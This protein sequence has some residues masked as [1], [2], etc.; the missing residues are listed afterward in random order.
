MQLL[1]VRFIEVDLGDGALN[2]S[3]GEHAD[4][5]APREQALYL[6]KLL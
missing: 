5:L 4:L 1:H 6:F 2:L 3:V